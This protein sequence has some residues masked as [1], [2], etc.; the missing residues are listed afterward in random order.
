MKRPTKGK[1]HQL[2]LF[3]P[4][5]TNVSTLDRPMSMMHLKWTNDQIVL[6]FLILIFFLYTHPIGIMALVVIVNLNAL[7]NQELHQTPNQHRET[8]S[9]LNNRHLII[10]K[11][12]Q[13]SNTLELIIAH[14]KFIPALT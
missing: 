10:K 5:L 14:Q 8:E 6:Q 12:L 1:L 2:A 11:A 3:Y 4:F 7:H 9:N 13:V